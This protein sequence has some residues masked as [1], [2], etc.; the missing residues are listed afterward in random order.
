MTATKSGAAARKRY[1][2]R[3]RLAELDRQPVWLASV[4]QVD[5][6]LVSRWLSGDKPIPDPRL[7]EIAI[8]LHRPVE[9]FVG[10]EEDLTR[11]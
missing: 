10:P 9:W 1:R 6:S 2:I 4:L 3:L 7:R 5:L 8:A 11:T